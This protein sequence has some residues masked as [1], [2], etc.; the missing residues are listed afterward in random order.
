MKT[1]LR[2][3]LFLVLIGGT[4]FSLQAQETKQIISKY[5]QDHASDWK[6]EPSDVSS[7]EIVSTASSL[8]KEAKHYYI[9]QLKNNWPVV[10]GLA[11]VTV[12]N[13][14]VVYVAP[15]LVSLKSENTAAPVLSAEDAVKKAFATLGLPE[16]S[17]VV[18]SENKTEQS[19]IFEKTAYT[20]ENIPVR[21]FLEHINGKLEYVWDLSVYPTGTTNWWSM[22]LS[23]VDGTELFRNNW[24]VSCSAESCS[25]ETHQHAT[26][27]M[28][29]PPPPPGMNQY[30]VYALPAE[31]PNHGNKIVVTDPADATFSPFGWHDTNG[32]DGAEHTITRGNNVYAYDD[33]DDDNAPGYSPDGGTDL[34]FDFP[35]DSLLGPS[36]N[37][38]VIVT[39]LFYM[40]NMIHDI[41][42]HYGFD[43]ES[44]NFQEMNY[45]GTNG[46]G[47][48]VMAEAQDGS[49]TDN[50]N[51]ATPPD[52]QNPRMQMYLWGDLNGSTYL[53]V[54][55]PDSLSGGYQTGTATFGPDIP[56]LNPITEDLV[57]VID[58]GAD[59]TDACNNILNGPSLN[60]KIALVRRGN[61][62]NV[63]KVQACEA[64]GAIA[65]VVINT[66]DPAPGTMS[67]TV[68]ANDPIEIP[69]CIISKSDGDAIVASLNAGAT[70]NITLNG[71]TGVNAFDS[72]LDNGVIA[73]EYGHGM[74][75]RLVG[76][77]GNANC[78]WNDEQLGE[79]WSDWLALIVT[80]NVGDQGGDRRGMGTYLIGESTLGTGIR[81][82]PYST[83]PSFNNY[84]LGHSNAMTGVHDRGF[85]WATMLWDLTWDLIDEEGYDPNLTSGTGGNNIAMALVIE[86]MKQTACNSGFESA[87]DGILAADQLLYAGEYECLI[88][89]AFAE[90][91]L[92]WGASSGDEDVADDQ[93]EDFTV[94]VNC[95]SGLTEMGISTI[96]AF[97]NPG[98]GQVTVNL[99]N[100]KNAQQ[101]VVTDLTGKIINTRKLS[102]DKEVLLDLSDV[103]KGIYLI[104]VT[105]GN[106]THVI[107]WVKQ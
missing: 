102:G 65:V 42:G 52:G 94:P 12:K 96:Y 14:Q 38:D 90:R 9:R 56:V 98:T 24:F 76:G 40:N 4:H 33:I 13:G 49:G 55:D 75:N 41:W 27:A 87:R 105:D 7:I 85:I 82:A 89:N 78:M 35:Y 50:A 46:S 100:C 62:T 69:S 30:G 107:E 53:V 72:D 2:L 32:A 39:N 26:S 20:N 74:S 3:V 47:D 67:G 17:L 79:G 34:D 59:T 58:D 63:S 101:L 95:L 22:R 60:G 92:G 97:P 1:A 43:E 5:L 77:S 6:L 45:T 93:I 10:N 54:N 99:S 104:R 66:T 23:A 61:C 8:N 25:V 11:S 19:V 88:W 70:V 37:L 80:M 28:A 86:G 21:L 18:I 57:L 36:G 15:S 44:G 48:G 71:L 68:P 106:G 81:P 64:L 29:P 16:P 83:N 91:G 73:H 84:K 103:T 31:S 51:F